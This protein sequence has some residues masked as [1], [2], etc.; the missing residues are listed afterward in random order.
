MANKERETADTVCS[1]FRKLKPKERE[2]VIARLLQNGEFLED[3]ED[4]VTMRLRKRRARFVPWDDVKA[5][6]KKRAN[7]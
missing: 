4:V 2:E 3:L 1:T 6:L 5:D 7:A